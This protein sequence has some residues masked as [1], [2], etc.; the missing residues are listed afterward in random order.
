MADTRAKMDYL[1]RYIISPSGSGTLA[2]ISCRDCEDPPFLAGNRQVLF[3]SA[4]LCVLKHE[5]DV[6]GSRSS[7]LNPP[8]D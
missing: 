3:R 2:I 7:I 6:H 1:D 4:L 8:E 5:M